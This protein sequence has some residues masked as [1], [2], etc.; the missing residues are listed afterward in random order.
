MNQSSRLINNEKHLMSSLI[1]YPEFFEKIKVYGNIF[2]QDEMKKLYGILEHLVERDGKYDMI[3][4]YEFI[5]DGKNYS[6]K[7]LDDIYEMFASGDH[8]ELYLNIVLIE[9]LKKNLQ[10]FSLKIMYNDYLKYSDIKLELEDLVKNIK[11]PNEDTIKRIDIIC[12]DALANLYPDK[13]KSFID[14]FDKNQGGFEND[15]LIYI[16]ARPGIGKTQYA[17]NL[18]IKDIKNYK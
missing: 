5:Q 8:F 16:A 6:R 7:E 1:Q 15:E 12:R 4:L 2:E 9:K 17:K 3:S 14:F 13:V 11:V 10:N 18:I